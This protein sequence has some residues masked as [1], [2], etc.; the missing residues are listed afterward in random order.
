MCAEQLGDQGGDARGSQPSS[1]QSDEGASAGKSLSKSVRLLQK[2]RLLLHGEHTAMSMSTDLTPRA[3]SI[4][5]RQCGSM[6]A[7]FSTRKMMSALE[8]LVLSAWRILATAA[9]RH[10]R[11]P[12]RPGALH[13]FARLRSWHGKPAV[14]RNATLCSFFSS[15]SAS[16]S[17][18]RRMCPVSVSR[19]SS[20]TSPAGR[21]LGK[22]LL[23]CST[24]R[25]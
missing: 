23:A 21:A 11:D 9:T 7:T 15:S 22:D 17:S 10:E 13:L 24:N 12:R 1:R 19:M 4:C 14:T 5:P 25:G 2:R 20:T 18:M 6:D 3:L 16:T 8:N